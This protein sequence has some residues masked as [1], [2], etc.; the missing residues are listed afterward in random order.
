MLRENLICATIQFC[1]RLDLALWLKGDDIIKYVTW[2]NCFISRYVH[3][4][5]SNLL[6]ID[7]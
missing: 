1:F 5:R 3:L 2:A 7:L 6:I 4:E